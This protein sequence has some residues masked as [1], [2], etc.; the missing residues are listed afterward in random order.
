MYSVEGPRFQ[1]LWKIECVFSR[2]FCEMGP[3]FKDAFDHTV[4][5]V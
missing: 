3:S 4:T 5:H 2:N 1:G